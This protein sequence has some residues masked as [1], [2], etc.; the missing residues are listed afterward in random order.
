MARRTERIGGQYLAL[1]ELDHLLKEIRAAKHATQVR[2]V[3]RWHPRDELAWAWF[4]V[5]LALV[6]VEWIARRRAGLV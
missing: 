5:F 6:T 2:Q 3:H 1:E 4:A